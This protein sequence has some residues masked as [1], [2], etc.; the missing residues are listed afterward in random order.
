MKQQMLQQQQQA[1]LTAQKKKKNKKKKKKA[2]QVKRGHKIDLGLL[3]SQAQEQE[4]KSPE[5]VISELHTLFEGRF[6]RQ[7][8]ATVVSMNSD[9]FQSSLDYLCALEQDNSADTVSAP[10]VY[11]GEATEEYAAPEAENLSAQ[12]A[13]ESMSTAPNAEENAGE[14]VPVCRYFLKGC[15]M[16]RNCPFRHSTADVPCSF[17]AQGNC[18]KGDNCPFLHDK[19]K[20]YG[21]QP[22]QATPTAIQ[23]KN[24]EP[25]APQFFQHDFPVLPTSRKHG[26]S[27]GQ[28]ASQPCT[29]APSPSRTAPLPPPIFLPHNITPFDWSCAP[30]LDMA[31]HL[32]LQ[33][34]LEQYGWVPGAVVEAVFRTHNCK[35]A[36][37]E[38]F[39]RDA[40]PKPPQW[41]PPSAQQTDHKPT[42]FAEKQ[43]QPQPQ[44]TSE[45]DDAAR[46]WVDTG[47]SVTQL[48]GEARE[49]AALFAELRNMHF[50]QATAAYMAG[51]K[52]AAKEHSRKGRAYG[53]RMRELHQSAKEHIL[54]ERSTHLVSVLGEG[55]AEHVI[56]LHG[57]HANEALDVLRGFITQR[58][59]AAAGSTL[60]VIT[61]TGHHAYD[62]RAHVLP[63]VTAF[64]N[65][66]RLPYADCSTDGSCGMLRVTLI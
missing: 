20:Q 57:L 47:E 21:W 48:Y 37:T 26:G 52:P 49:E 44:T 28:V 23:Q 15:C 40:F 10:P 64:L 16:V 59:D 29:A 38:Q 56:D 7:S 12:Y 31:S 1:V 54:R 35:A 58:K 18:F 60:Y 13:P 6:D 62:G 33:K 65:E 46:V 14:E 4:Q 32:Q 25:M 43:M 30:P 11:F 45:L 39:L 3:Q 9:D 2:Q 41:N 17:F 50:R 8:I 42:T 53:D 34:F 36:P 5:Q 19:P 51:D 61:G 27:A 66:R 55:I 22:M 63:A 24:K